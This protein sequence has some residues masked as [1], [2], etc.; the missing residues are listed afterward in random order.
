[1][2]G[3]DDRRRHVDISVIRFTCLTNQKRVEVYR[4]L[5]GT[6]AVDAD[7]V[8]HAPHLLQNVSSLDTL[9]PQE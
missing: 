6:P 9:W 4:H 8:R 2:R 3:L 7:P 5:P 1:M